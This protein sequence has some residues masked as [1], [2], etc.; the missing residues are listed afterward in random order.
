M[1]LAFG[2]RAAQA[3]DTWFERIDA[4]AGQPLQLALG[5]GAHFPRFES[6]VQLKFVEH[7]ACT[8]A[9]GKAIKPEPAREGRRHTVLR[10]AGLDVTAF[11]CVARLQPF[12]IDLTPA[13]VDAYFEE[14]RAADALRAAVAQQRLQ[15]RGF[16]ERYLKVARIEG[17][18]APPRNS[19]QPLDVLR[20]APGGELRAGA[21]VTFE[22]QRD[23]KP[24]SA[25]PVQLL[26]DALPAGLWAR[27]DDAG[28]IRVRLALPGRWLLRGVDLRPPAGEGARWESRFITYSFEATR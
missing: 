6:P 14:I 20:V 22:V 26:H 15:R 5:T 7:L 13:L 18:L 4:A 23:G 17:T 3:H 11:S 9:M 12:E 19:V 8:D 2:P 10:V 24:L 28:R 1:A 27:T 16:Q 25:L 21:E